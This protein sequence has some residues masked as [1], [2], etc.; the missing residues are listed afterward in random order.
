MRNRITYFVSAL[1]CAMLAVPQSAMGQIST[2][3]YG[4][5]Q[6]V[7]DFG[8]EAKDAPT[9][10]ATTKNYY[11][12]TQTSAEGGCYYLEA[13][14]DADAS[15]ST[16]K[17]VTKVVS[18]TDRPIYSSA[19]PNGDKGAGATMSTSQGY[20]E[21]YAP[22]TGI[23]SVT[24]NYTKRVTIVDK[25]NSDT[26]LYTGSNG[27]KGDGT[28]TASSNATEGHR[29]QFYSNNGAL[30]IANITLT[31]PGYGETVTAPELSY[32]D[33]TLTLISAG[34]SSL[35]YTS[36]LTTYYT[37]D[38]TEPTSSSSV[39]STSAAIDGSVT[40]IKAKTISQYGT[41]SAVI[42]LYIGLTAV[43]EATSWSFADYSFTKS[44]TEGQ[45]LADGTLYV[46]ANVTYDSSSKRAYFDGNL[47]S[48]PTSLGEKMISIKTG[49]AGQVIMR[50]KDYNTT[51]AV[52]NGTAEPY[53]TYVGGNADGTTVAKA[54]YHGGGTYY[55]LATFQ[56]EAG[57]TYYIYGSAGSQPGVFDIEFIPNGNTTTALAEAA[58][59]NFTT[60]TEIKYRLPEFYGITFQNF[61]FGNGVQWVYEGSTTQSRLKFTGAGNTTTGE[62]T[63]SFKIPANT[64]GELVVNPSSY[65]GNVLLT[66]GTQTLETYTQDNH[67]KDV[68]TIIQPAATERT[69][70]FYTEVGTPNNVGIFKMSWTPITEVTATI[71]DTGF[72]TFASSYALNLAEI[73][74]GTAFYASSVADGK[75]TLTS[76]EASVAANTGLMLKGTP[77]ATVTIPVLSSA[78][79]LDGNKLVGCATAQTITNETPNYANFYVL[80]IGEGS[81]AEFQNI[82][83]YVDTNT[84]LSIPAGKAYLDATGITLSRLSIMF[85]DDIT[86]G[87]NNA[88]Q[89][90][91]E[92]S[93]Y[94]NLA[95]QRV[96]RPLKGLYIANGKKV[97]MK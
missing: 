95:G 54:S 66:D 19:K 12:K 25:S 31:E 86:T 79:A 5:R 74:G 52:S 23:I 80:A 41:E 2:D 45:F 14:T 78:D 58:S 94:Y 33:G 9:E 84:S 72:T 73:D 21:F 36:T 92:I 17:T 97:V 13:T 76:T 7:W 81:K 77:G 75:V 34:S 40:T 42:T 8:V 59:W 68:T 51:V 65:N 55:I 49:V 83:N 3:E 85:D 11:L 93:G 28:I 20:I 22:F 38:G 39:L 4:R 71:G 30:G 90:N 16:D 69:L 32:S 82:K 37:T 88:T 89:A 24:G 57:T 91:S 70:Y 46:G 6:Y 1:L 44:T 96:A 18:Y 29:I 67:I 60:T 63:F 62:N 64:G 43:S 56:A 26:K 15:Y 53:K 35:A 47:A 48:A 61:Y 87:V 10:A 27:S 50:L